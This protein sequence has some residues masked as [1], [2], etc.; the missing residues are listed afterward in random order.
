MPDLFGGIDK[1]FIINLVERSDR[2][3]QMQ[4]QLRKL[5]LSLQDSRVELFAA[6]RPDAQL[7]WPSLG[8]RG[9]FQSH[10]QIIRNA[11][12]RGLQ[13]VMVLEDDCDFIDAVMTFWPALSSSLQTLDWDIAYPGHPL[14]ASDMAGEWRA[15][16]ES[17]GL[18]HCYIV[19]RS[20]MPVLLEFLE[21]VMARPAGHPLGGPQHYDGALNTFYFQY[22]DVK[23]V[24]AE[25]SIAFQR[26]SRSDISTGRFDAMPVIGRLIALYRALRYRFT[27]R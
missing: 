5:G 6:A 25:P 21:T 22:P 9:C 27:G 11:Y 16:R 2:R 20:V 13:A 19:N 23:V 1:V 4:R 3:R 14:P 17:I 26:R 8:A 12:D 10:Y 7:D 18:A 24:V 15:T